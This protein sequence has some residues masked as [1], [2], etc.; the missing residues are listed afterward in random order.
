MRKSFFTVVSIALGTA[1]WVAQEPVRAHH[2]FSAEYD[3]QQPIVLKGTI[4]RMEWVNPHVW[5]H[6]DVK[7][8]S[9]KV[10][11]WALEFGSPNTLYKRGWR[12]DDLPVGAEVTIDGF[13]AKDGSPMA[14]A[15]TAMLAGGKKLFGG[16]PEGPGASAEK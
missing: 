9:G 2:A 10:V 3:A 14:N 16:S 11:Q 13:K 6:I 4:V 7:D 8:P 1:L 12:K 5:L 15:R